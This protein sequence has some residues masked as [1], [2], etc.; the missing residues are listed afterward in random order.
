MIVR[1]T[2]VDKLVNDFIK[3]WVPNHY[4]HLV[5]SDENDGEEL[6]QNLKRLIK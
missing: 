2:K 6:R 3:K 4:A 5:D 1:T